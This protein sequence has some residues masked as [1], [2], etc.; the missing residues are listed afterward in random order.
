MSDIDKNMKDFPLTQYGFNQKLSEFENKILD[1]EN[2]IVGQNNTI[3]SLHNAI[4]GLKNTL[5]ASINLMNSMQ[6]QIENQGST[7]KSLV[8]RCLEEK[9]S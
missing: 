8:E 3:N 9:K 1:L 4:D 5:D 7:I 6:T 2:K